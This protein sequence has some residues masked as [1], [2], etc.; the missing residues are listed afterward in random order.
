[1][2]KD[3]FARKSIGTE[4]TEAP[5]FHQVF[6]DVYAAQGKHVVGE[7]N[8]SILAIDGADKNAGITRRHIDLV[9]AV[10]AA[11]GRFWDK[12]AYQK[13]IENVR[14][15]LHALTLSAV[16]QEHPNGGRNINGILNALQAHDHLLMD[17]EGIRFVRANSPMDKMIREERERIALIAEQAMPH[18][19]S[20]LQK[21]QAVESLVA[22]RSKTAGV[23][24]T[25]HA[26]QPEAALA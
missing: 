5:D 20:P 10:K 17:Y 9:S 15:G 8:I 12:P 26:E 11:E 19:L 14:A 7:S 22:A 1:M 25:I 18:G 24:N 13:G 23:K 3:E 16:L 21:E 4:S 2:G 6:E